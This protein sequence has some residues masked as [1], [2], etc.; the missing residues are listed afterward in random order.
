MTRKTKNS[1]GSVVAIEIRHSTLVLARIEPAGADGTRRV[2]TR[3]VRWREKANS[4]HGERG[5]RELSAAL[6]TLVV[7]EKLA[8]TPVSLTLNGDYCVIRV[9]TGSTDRVR[10]EL[11]LLKDRSELYL[12]LGKG[13]K[14]LATSIYE[15]DARHQHALL[16]VTNGKTLEAIV[17]IA[18]DVGLEVPLVEPSLVALCRLL[19]HT[20]RDADQPALIIA[21]GK[22]GVELGISHQGQLLLDYRPGGRTAHGD[23]A[24]IVLRHLSRLRR[25]CDRYYRYAE[26]KLSRVYLCGAPGLVESA[27]ARFQ[28]QDELTAE[29]LDPNG[30]DPKWQ[31]TEASPDSVLCAALGTCVPSISS[32]ETSPGP[33]LIEQVHAEA[34]RPTVTQF[35]LA[36]WPVAAAMLVAFGLL[37][38]N[39]YEQSQCSELTAI[40]EEF[41]PDVAELWQLRGEMIQVDTK[42]AHLESLAEAD[43]GPS[44]GT[45]L[46]TV[47]QCMPKDLW[48]DKITANSKGQVTFNGSSYSEATIY[49]FVGYLESVSIWSQVALEGTWPAVGRM[50]RTTKFDVQCEF[51]GSSDRSEGLSSN[52]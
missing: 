13:R 21:F 23:V 45:L 11:A 43:R 5:V 49:E 52:D 39:H 14:S 38:V 9:V 42:I 26:G 7:E 29:V 2:H 1:A 36:F 37:A 51:S 10:R 48:M 19:G 25:Y 41:E 47:A 18:A 22:N 24:D 31:F 32:R 44:W 40:L 15:L 3:S 4:L 17:Q 34:A 16:A 46:S 35:C 33:N 28:E 8:G 12:S 27:L 30:I 6:R 20:G 50:G